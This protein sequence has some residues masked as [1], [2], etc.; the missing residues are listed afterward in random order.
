[1]AVQ[2]EIEP[3]N[4]LK[5]DLDIQ[6]VAIAGLEPGCHLND[7]HA[8]K[9]LTCV[10][11]QVDVLVENVGSRHAMP[12]IRN[13]SE[14]LELGSGLSANPEGSP[15]CNPHVRSLWKRLDRRVRQRS[16]RRSEE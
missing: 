12:L 7:R 8:R 16:W 5:G 15:N 11:D 1:M 13:D 4:V 3:I 6:R 14:I 2:V 9:K 10:F